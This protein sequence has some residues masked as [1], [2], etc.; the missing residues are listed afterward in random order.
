MKKKELL[1]MPK[2]SPTTYMINKAVNDRADRTH[3]PK[4][5]R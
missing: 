5:T 4:S 1:A 2:L 3:E